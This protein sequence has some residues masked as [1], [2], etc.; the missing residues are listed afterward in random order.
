MLHRFVLKRFRGSVQRRLPCWSVTQTRTLVPVKLTRRHIHITS[1]TTS[2]T[3][4]I[5]TT[6]TNRH[7]H[8]HD[9]ASYQRP[10]LTP[11]HT[12]AAPDPFSASVGALLSHT[13][14]SRRTSLFATRSPLFAS[15]TSLPDQ[16]RMRSHTNLPHMA[17]PPSDR[18]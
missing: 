1:T 11:V 16:H 18:I 7:N 6:T 10:I 9:V 14:H 3:T 2:F 4:T 5:T 13:V 17:Y 15:F 12:H 8:N